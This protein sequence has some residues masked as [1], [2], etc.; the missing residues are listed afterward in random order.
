M[1][2]NLDKINVIKREQ[3]LGIVNGLCLMEEVDK[4]V[5]FGSAIR[6]DCREDSDLDI[7]IKWTQECYD[8]DGVMK[9]F[10]LPACRIISAVTKGNNDLINIGHEGEQLRE[11]IRGGIVV[12]EKDLSW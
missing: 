3:V 5:I 6:D 10:T 2:K 8:A 9:E 12:F 1:I 7:A 11:S 4:I